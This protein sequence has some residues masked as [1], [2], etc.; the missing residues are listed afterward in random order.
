MHCNHLAGRINEE[1]TL[2]SVPTTKTLMQKPSSK[3]LIRQVSGLFDHDLP[4]GRSKCI[5]AMI[6]KAK[7]HL[8]QG[9]AD[10][11]EREREKSTI[12]RIIL[13]LNLR[14]ST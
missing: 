4:N 7:K 6:Y 10:K 5:F 12:G 14:S 1:M 9:K 2:N 13:G 3:I 11:R 8:D